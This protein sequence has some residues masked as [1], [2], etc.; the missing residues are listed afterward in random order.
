M[1]L[2][3]ASNDVFLREVDD[4]LRRDQLIGFWRQW[5]RWLIGAVVAAL[6]V[7]AGVLWWNHHRDVVAQ[8][9]DKTLQGG[10]DLMAASNVGGA[11]KVFEGLKDAHGAGY[12][13][14]AAFSRADLLVAK[15]DLKGAAAIFAGVAADSGVAKPFRDLAVVRQ[16][17]LEYDQLQPQVVIERLRPLAT[18]DSAWLGSAGEM[19]A[20]AYLRQGRAD[21]ARQTFS[22]VAAG[23]NVPDTIRQRAVQMAGGLTPASAAA[24]PATT[25][26]A[27][28]TA[29]KA[30]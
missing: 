7:F 11:Q 24:T 28:P 5:G 20:I 15:N 13:A 23:E 1:A 10:Y 16:T 4:E 6:A 8:E 17:S 26:P 12:R 21:L 29:R 25:T 3:P 19:L 27:A 9:T 2:P 22:L 18:K 14:L 30:S